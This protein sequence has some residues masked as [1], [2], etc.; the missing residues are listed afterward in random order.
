M[1]LDLKWI[2]VISGEWAGQ[3]MCITIYLCAEE[4]GA[5]KAL[6]G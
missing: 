5:D 4:I 6:D 3:V 1:D 2:I